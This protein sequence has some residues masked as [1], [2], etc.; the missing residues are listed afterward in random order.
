MR[1]RESEDTERVFCRGWLQPAISV[2]LRYGLALVSV[3]AAFVLAQAFVYY[4]LPQPFTAFALSAITITFWCGG[5]K[6]AF[7]RP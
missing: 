6:P 5:T 3:L 4:H 1:R 7:L 2:A